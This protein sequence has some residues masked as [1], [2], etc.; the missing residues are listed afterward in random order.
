MEINKLLLKKFNNQKTKYY[1][2]AIIESKIITLE[3]LLEKCKNK[4]E[5]KNVYNELKKIQ[6]RITRHAKFKIN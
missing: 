3:V 5:I 4:T 2:E 6:Q 1:N